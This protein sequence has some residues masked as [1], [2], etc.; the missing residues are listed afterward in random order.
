[1]S[2]AYAK[3][4]HD[5]QPGEALKQGLEVDDDLL[6]DIESAL[7]EDQGLRRHTV[8][9]GDIG[10]V[11]P[12]DEVSELIEKVAVCQLPNTQTWF[13]GVTSIR[14]NMIPVFDLHALFSI[15]PPTTS[16][17]L[18]VVGQNETAA[19]FWVD[20]FPRLLVFADEEITTNEPSIPSL[21]RKHAR[22]YFLQ[23]GKT[24]VEWDFKSFFATLG[25][26]L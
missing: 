18:I 16:R 23:D 26:Q 24:W 20:D 10:L 9:V 12:V 3:Q 13:N 2:S 8:L 22:Q 1:M 11:L 25:E 4:E 6:F 14:G 15:E 21:V 17:R 7:E 19:A 5:M